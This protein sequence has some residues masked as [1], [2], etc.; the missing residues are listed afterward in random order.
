MPKRVQRKRIKGY[1][2]PPNTVSVTRP[3]P[4]GNPYVIRKRENGYWF[5]YGPNLID[6]GVRCDDEEIAR[7][8]AVGLFRK[9]WHAAIA[10]AAR[11]G[12]PPMPFGKPVYLG[13]LKGKN[14]ACFCSL[15]KPCHV[16]VLLNI[17]NN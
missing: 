1:K 7:T 4:Y 16:D 13:P 3:G 15:E 10:C 2:M 8:L 5:V 6:A 11:D 17:A 14:L 12:T 9:A